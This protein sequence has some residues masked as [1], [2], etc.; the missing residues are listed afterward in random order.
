M[1]FGF[2]VG[3]FL[4]VIGVAT[5]IRKEFAGAPI[6]YK[7]LSD[8]VKSL[9]VLIQDVEA[10]TTGMDPVLQTKVNHA[11]ESSNGVLHDL[12]AFIEKNKSITSKN[13]PFRRA[14]QRISMDSQEIIDLRSRISSNILVLKAFTEGSMRATLVKIEQ[15][16][17]SQDRRQDRQNIFDRIGED[18]FKHQRDIQS[19]LL[20]MRQLGTRQWLFESPAWKAWLNTRGS[21]LYCLGMPGAGKTF[22]TAMVIENLQQN[23]SDQVALA[24]IFSEY[25]QQNNPGIINAFARSTLRMLLEHLETLPEEI[26]QWY[27]ERRDVDVGQIYALLRI[28]ATRRQTTFIIDALDELNPESRDDLLQYLSRLQQQ[29]AVNVFFTSREIP[30]IKIRITKNFPQLA[31]IE[32]KATEDDVSI[33]V[34]QSMKTLPKVVQN[35]KSLQD[36]IK[37]TIVKSTGGM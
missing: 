4:A 17:E 8:E 33:Y 30:E 15:K 16:L 19:G 21:T 37:S 7:A 36:D 10:E 29:A 6:Q 27:D 18:D 11:I 3:D 9:S 34:D 35:D 22:T 26:I 12:Y 24:Y 20:D 32:V 25:Q 23:R 28:V 1:S 14:W 2:G 13:S 5:K 31:M